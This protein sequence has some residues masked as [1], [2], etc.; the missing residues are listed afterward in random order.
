MVRDLTDQK[1]NTRTFIMQILPRIDRFPRIHLA[2]M[3]TQ[4]AR[5]AATVRTVLQTS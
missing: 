4:T 3:L 5:R 1:E 2:P